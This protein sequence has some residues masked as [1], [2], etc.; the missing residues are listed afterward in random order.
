LE[1]CDLSQLFNV[2]WQSTKSGAKPPHSK[3]V[4]SLDEIHAFSARVTNKMLAGEPCTWTELSHL[5][6]SHERHQVGFFLRVEI[7]LQDKIEELNR[8]FQR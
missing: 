8:V 4:A 1:C 2:E 5:Q 7:E 6:H 3:V